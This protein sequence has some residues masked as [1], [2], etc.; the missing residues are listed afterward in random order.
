MTTPWFSDNDAWWN[1]NDY[2]VGHAWSS[3]SD[4]YNVN[5]VLFGP[6]GVEDMHAQQ[7]FMDAYFE[8]NT[9]AYIDLIDYMWREYGIDF[10]DAFS[11]ADFRE[12]YD[13]QGV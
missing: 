13:A 12:W 5:E 10:E 3:S 6:P 7:L 4:A 8:N 1:N 9:R 11:W 2:F